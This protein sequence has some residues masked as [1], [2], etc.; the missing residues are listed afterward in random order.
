MIE[1]CAVSIKTS[2]S[3]RRC[4]S[5]VG[6]ITIGIHG[7]PDNNRKPARRLIAPD[8]TPKKQHI[9]QLQE[10]GRNQDGIINRIPSLYKGCLSP[11]LPTPTTDL[12][13]DFS[14]HKKA[15]QLKHFPHDDKTNF[16]F[17]GSPTAGQFGRTSPPGS[18]SGRSVYRN[19]IPR[20][21]LSRCHR[22]LRRRTTQSRYPPR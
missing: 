9:S 11:G 22:S 3:S 14:I 15:Y 7:A 4:V 20:T 12:H 10:R 17:R 18:R 13:I 6:D 21:Y 16:Y 19:R 8:P 1:N 2:S 5:M